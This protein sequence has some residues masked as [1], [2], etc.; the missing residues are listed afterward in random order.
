M[1]HSL[2]PPGSTCN[3]VMNQLMPLTALWHTQ[4]KVSSEFYC[5][6]NTLENFCV[7]PPLQMIHTA[8]RVSQTIHLR[9]FCRIM[10]LLPQLTRQ[11]E[12]C[13]LGK[14]H[15]RSHCL[16]GVRHTCFRPAGAQNPWN[17]PTL[18]QN[19][20]LFVHTP[21]ELEQTLRSVHC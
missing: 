8:A 3:T 1:L 6:S 4:I 7:P 16:R 2:Q 17:T 20:D 14:L 21:D 15:L 18:Q 19:H 13:G 12:G 10:S 11:F 5:L 9:L